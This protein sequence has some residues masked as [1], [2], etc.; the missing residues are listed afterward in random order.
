MVFKKLTTVLLILA[1]AF[2]LG[3]G[4]AVMDGAGCGLGIAAGMC[5]VAA[6][7]AERTE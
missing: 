1:A 5:A 2:A 7:W 6:A 3:A 4:N